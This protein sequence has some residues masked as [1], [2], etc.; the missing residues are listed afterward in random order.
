M[1]GE[2]FYQEQIN[3][4]RRSQ[5][6]LAGYCRQE[7]EAGRTPITL[8]HHSVAELEKTLTYPKTLKE[9]AAHLL[10]H[11]YEQGG[12]EGKQFTLQNSTDYP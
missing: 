3:L 6:V 12:N 10:R 9:K 4:H 7:H 11:L 8:T 1:I 2:M 5:P